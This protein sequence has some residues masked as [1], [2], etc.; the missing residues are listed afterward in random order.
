MSKP[1][2]QCFFH[3]DTSTCTFVVSDPETKHAWIIDPVL[4]FDSAS[5]R[6]NNTHNDLIVDY[7]QSQLLMVD[8]IVETHVH[9]DH[10]TGAHYLKSK[11][12]TAKTGIGE[13]VALVQ[14]VFKGVFNLE[15]SFPT[16]GSQFDVLF[17]DGQEI[18]V[19]NIRGTVLYTPGHTPACVSYVLGDAVFSGDTIFMPDFG[20][21]RCDFPKGSAELLYRSVQK[22]Y[23][24]DDATRVFVGHD[25]Q[26]GGRNVAWETTIGEQK[27]SNKH[28][29][30]DT[31][32]EEFIQW[33]TERD[34][35]L[36]MPKLIIPSLQ[37]NLR[38]GDLPPPESNGVS[39]LKIPMNVL[40]ADK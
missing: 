8:Y 26:P 24:L 21:A 32:P 4:D 13:N 31:T 18:A 27:R 17:R 25:Y 1:D 39:Y 3:A 11:F 2:V 33:R 6:A 12:P 36:P 9:A 10:L 15:E 40:G 38:N 30:A 16:D 29:R 19:G 5:G 28:I 22:L 37:V 34:A 7:C 20:S 35:T 14:Q 23:A